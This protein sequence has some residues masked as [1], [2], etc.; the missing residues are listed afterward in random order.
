MKKEIME[1]SDFDKILRDKLSENHGLHQR[2]METAK[3]FVW[4][5]VYNEIGRK[6]TLTWY[7]L[8]A[9]V[10]LLMITFSVTL[11]HVQKGHQNEYRN[12]RKRL[13]NWKKPFEPG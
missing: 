5:A 2:E 8:A 13:I 10:L 1:T 9:A 11:V 4:S 7:H 3:P 6:K 12:C